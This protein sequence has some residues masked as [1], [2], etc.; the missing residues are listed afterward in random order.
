MPVQFA[1]PKSGNFEMPLNPGPY[2]FKLAAIVDEG[3][4]DFG[5]QL[6]W[7]WEA[8][9]TGVTANE[10]NPAAFNADGST[11][12][13]KERTSTKFGKNPKSG[14][15]AKARSRAEALLKRTIDDDEDVSELP[16]QLI[17]KPA[18]VHLAYKT[19]SDG[20]SQYL[21][22]VHIEPYKKGMVAPL[23][24]ISEDDDAALPASAPV[25]DDLPF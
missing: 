21:Q 14:M 8:F 2:I 15:V 19:A 22:I 4:G 3:E 16:E 11:F 13:F 12:L 7:H 23:Q 24:I 10:I 5:Q 6:G 17:G 20:R 18:F 25:A 9:N 1:N